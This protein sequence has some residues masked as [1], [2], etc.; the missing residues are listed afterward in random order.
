[1]FVLQIALGIV[2]G[3][4]VLVGGAHVVGRILEKV[5]PE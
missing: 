3:H 2:L 4:A 5:V 1:M